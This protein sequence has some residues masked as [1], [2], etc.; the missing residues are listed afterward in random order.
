MDTKGGHEE[1]VADYK[2]CPRSGSV[3]WLLV[4]SLHAYSHDQCKDLNA[5]CSDWAEKGECEKNP[6]YMLDN[7]KLSCGKC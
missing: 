5:S 4:F 6:G 2:T 1:K 3:S 7:C